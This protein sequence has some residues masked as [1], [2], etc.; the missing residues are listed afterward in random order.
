MI[1]PEAE[2]SQAER[3]AM[4]QRHAGARFLRIDRG[5]ATET[6]IVLAGK[7]MDAT[8][9]QPADY[10][11]ALGWP[12]VGDLFRRGVLYFSREGLT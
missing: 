1:V 11:E 9:F 5:R 6:D 8:K 10:E 2:V 3:Y 12:G 7:V 4:K